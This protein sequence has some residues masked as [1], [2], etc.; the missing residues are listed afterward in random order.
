MKVANGMFNRKSMCAANRSKREVGLFF[1]C[2][3][4]LLGLPALAQVDMAKSSVTATAKQLGVPIEGAFKKLSATVIFN[5]A[6]LA[7]SSAKVEIDVG[8]YDMGA[9]EYNKELTGKEWFNAAQ[10]PKATF[11]SSSISA[12]GADKYTVLGKL[13]LKGKVADVALPITVKSSKGFRT[14]DGVLP[15]KRTA[16]NI[17]EGEWKDTSVVADEVLIRFHIVAAEK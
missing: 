2:L 10:F 11:V 16:F 5:P 15:I 6:V 8:S 14:F 4:G 13:S 7:Q 1:L 17:G 12:A 9:P 3:S